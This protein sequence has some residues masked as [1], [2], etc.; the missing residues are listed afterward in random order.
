MRHIGQSLFCA[1]TRIVIPLAIVL[2]VFVSTGCKRDGKPS[3]QEGAS[4]DRI[5][6]EMIVAYQKADTYA[7]R[8]TIRLRYK[9]N[10]RQIEDAMDMSVQLARPNRLNVRVYRATVVCDGKRMRGRIEYE[11]NNN[12]DGQ[13][14]DRPAPEKM[15]AVELFPNEENADP[16]LAAELAS[17]LGG[18][19]VQLELLLGS[20]PLTRLL[21]EA[22]ERTLLEEGTIEDQAC[23]RV[24]LTLPDGNLVFWIDRESHV[25][26]RIEYPVKTLTKEMSRSGEAGKIEDVSLL[27]DLAE[28]RFDEELTDDV[29]RWELPDDAKLVPYIVEPPPLLSNLI[30][31]PVGEFA[32]T[33][34]ESSRRSSRALAGKIAVLVWFQ[35][36]PASRDNLKRLHEVYG[37]YKDDERIVFRTVCIEDATVMGHQD[38][39]NLV[40][41]WGVEAPVVR[42]LDLVGRDVFKISG[43]PTAIVLDGEGVVQLVEVGDNP[44]LGDELPTVLDRLLAGADVAGEILLRHRQA[45][46]EYRQFLESAGKGGSTAVIELPP[47]ETGRRTEPEHLKLTS[48]WECGDL[49]AP[50]NLLAYEDAE[51]R[52]RILVLDGFRTVV[53][54]NG[55]GKTVA[56]HELPLPQGTAV[57]WFRTALDGDGR[58]WFA[59]SQIRGTQFFVFDQDWKLAIAYPDPDQRHDG[60]G[61][62]QIADLD[63]DGKLE[64]CA[65]FWGLWGVHV[66]SLTGERLFSNRAVSSVLSIAVAPPGEEGNRSLLVTDDRGTV[67]RIDSQGQNPPGAGGR[68]KT[69]RPVGVRRV[70]PET[71]ERLLRPVVRP[72]RH[73]A[74]RGTGS[75]FEGGRSL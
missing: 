71:T 45:K 63:N 2:S 20:D 3:P 66:V 35:D 68:R 53:E 14:M 49:K 5:L 43:A 67:T 19:P 23:H 13:V 58:R 64:V 59:G 32:F 62:V 73:V 30:G 33:D 15:T 34:L 54:L 22:T 46:E 16:F 47:S 12:F 11:A 7:D 36:H 37:R 18:L 38:V 17:G 61:D 74:G 29:F 70:R 27:A 4:P 28:A 21:N 39:Q 25:L 1:P 52:T 31:K 41:H 57:A 60:I 75:R 72:L 50:G 6:Q 8:G 42:D 44:N 40:D 56:R 48:L 69:H 55:Q 65:G 51:G 26:R 10:G 24:Q 9:A